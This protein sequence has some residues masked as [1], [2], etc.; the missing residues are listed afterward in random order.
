VIPWT[1]IVPADPAIP[2]T[3]I[4]PADDFKNEINSEPPVDATDNAVDNIDTA[5]DSEVN[6]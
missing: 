6:Q 3:P 4:V 2:W 1:P 5:V